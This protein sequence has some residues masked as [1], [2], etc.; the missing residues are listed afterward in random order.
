MERAHVQNHVHVIMQIVRPVQHLRHLV[1]APL[2][3][4]VGRMALGHIRVQRD[5]ICRGRRVWRVKMGIT[6]QVITAAANVRPVIQIVQIGAMHRMT[7]IIPVTGRVHNRHVRPTQHVHM[8]I[9]LH[10]QII[11]IIIQL[12]VPQRPVRVH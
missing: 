12:L 5:T 11:G 10:R 1:M 2:V 3:V 7:V 6:V 9:H 4:V 8:V